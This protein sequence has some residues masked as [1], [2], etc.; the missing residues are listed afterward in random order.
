MRIT[1]RNLTLACATTQLTIDGL[2]VATFA[3]LF[4]AVRLHSFALL[5]PAAVTTAWTVIAAHNYFHRRDNFRMVY[6]NLAFLSYREWRIS[7]VMSHHMYPNSLHDLELSLF[8]PFLCWATDTRVKNALQRYASWLYGP[9]VYALMFLDQ[10]LKRVVFSVLDKCNRFHA[11]DAV[12]LTLPLFMYAVADASV[13]LATIVQMWLTVVV[14]AS[15][16]FSFVGLNAGHHNH[17]CVHDGDT[18]R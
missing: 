14:L 15:L 7:H 18:L 16:Y 10:L 11:T 13:A 1:N 3:L 2:L 9:G 17:Q 4:V 6:F 8:E 12:P 5:V